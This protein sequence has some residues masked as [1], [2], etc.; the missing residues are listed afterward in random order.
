MN[1][2]VIIGLVAAVVL[3]AVGGGAF[4]AGTKVAEN[5]IL[6]DPSRLFQQA[7]TDHASQFPGSGGPSRSSEG[8]TTRWGAGMMGAGGGTMGTI[9]AIEGDTLLV[10]TAQET[11]RVQMTGTT[12]IEKLMSV[13]AEDLEIGESVVVSGSR[14]DDGTLTARSI[15]SV[16]GLQSSMPG[17]Q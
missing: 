6:Q 15:R 5:R 17:Q 3:A 12:L 10:S 2:K 8:D 7:A 16:R 9:E 14:G 1:K 13:V 11:I 4:W